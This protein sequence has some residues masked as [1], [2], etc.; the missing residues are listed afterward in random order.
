MIDFGTYLQESLEGVPAITGDPSSIDFHNPEDRES[1]NQVLL[2]LT[3][4]EIDPVVLYERARQTLDDI[5]Y[6]IP[7]VTHHAK[8]FMDE[9]GEVIV[10]LTTPTTQG[11]VFFYFAWASDN[12]TE[13]PEILAEIVTPDELEEILQ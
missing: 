3:D 11:H 9:S 2:D 12:E 6:L 13:H 4:Q 10:P 7:S 5:G 1:V 8:M